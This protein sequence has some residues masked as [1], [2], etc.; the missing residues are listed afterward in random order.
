MRVSRKANSILKEAVRN[1]A[2]VSA[3]ELQNVGSVNMSSLIY[4]KYKQRMV[5]YLL[6]ALLALF[7]TTALGC[8]SAPLRHRAYP[9]LAQRKGS[10]RTVGLLPPEISMFEEVSGGRLVP[11]A[12]WSLAAIE[13]ISNIFTEV[14]AADRIQVV[15]I[16]TDDLEM[17]DLAD[18]YNAVEFSIQRHAWEKESSRH[19]GVSGVP[20]A[21][22]S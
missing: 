12:E 6:L 18:L 19:L 16:R 17:K 7:L 8:A 20:G 1:T 2:S 9:D 22:D 13:K 14:M 15:P 5:N 10:I 11:R 21:T 3:L 4:P